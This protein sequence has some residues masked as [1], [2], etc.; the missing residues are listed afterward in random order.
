M[1]QVAELGSP[2]KM[3]EEIRQKVDLTSDGA[4]VGVLSLR[5]WCNSGISTSLHMFSVILVGFNPS[6]ISQK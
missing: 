1:R 5:V 2:I 3:E 6:A 4:S